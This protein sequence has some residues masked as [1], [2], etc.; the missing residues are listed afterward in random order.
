MS[1]GTT[2]YAEKF[3]A[4]YNKEPDIYSAQT[5]DCYEALFK[6]MATGATTGEEIKNA[7][8]NVSFDGASGHVVFDKNGDVPANYIVYKITDGKFVM[9]NQ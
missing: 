9:Q 4:A 7:L 6:A 5:Y 2:A 1:D 8:Y 3:Q